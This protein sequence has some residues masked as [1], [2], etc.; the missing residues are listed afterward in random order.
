[1]AQWFI[2]DREGRLLDVQALPTRPIDARPASE[3][4][5]TPWY[6][7]EEHLHVEN[8]SIQGIHARGEN[9]EEV[10]GKLQ[11]YLAYEVFLLRAC[12]GA[13]DISLQ[14]ADAI[15]SSKR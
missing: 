2:L 9:A 12:G 1:M 7:R 5:F 15:L 8:G 13:E 3:D 10:H 14:K 4:L 11:G 6:K